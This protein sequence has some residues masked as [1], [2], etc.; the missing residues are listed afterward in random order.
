[1]GSKKLSNLLDLYK[2]DF[3]TDI[4]ALT[5]IAKR[6]SGNRDVIIQFLNNKAVYTD[7]YYIFLPREFQ[8][9]LKTAQGFIA[10][11]SGHQGYG[12]FELEFINLIEKLSIK[13]NL[14]KNFIKRAINIIEDVR[15]NNINKMKFPGF[16]ED[17]R[18]YTLKILP[19]LK[20]KVQIRQDILLYINLFMEDY[21][22]FETQPN[23]RRINFSYSDWQGIIQIKKLILKSL[24][25]STS[26]IACD[27]FC[28]ILSRY[29]IFRRNNQNY[30][31]NIK[32]IN[33]P[34]K[35]RYNPRTKTFI[36]EISIFIL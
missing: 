2:K 33:D 15:I 1:M 26:L 9:D 7:G 21:P 29:F 32:Q 23:F 16:Y 6:I 17:L 30:N 13:Y 24:T 12:S 22:G 3:N 34:Y 28:K 25:P 8:D 11:E 18:T 10:H 20:K 14:P 5:N 31:P 4:I 35:H 19:D 27:Q 36:T